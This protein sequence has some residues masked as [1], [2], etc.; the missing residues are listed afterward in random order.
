MIP[1]RNLMAAC[2]LTDALQS[3]WVADITVM[4]EEGPRVI[5]RLEKIRKAIIASPEPLLWFS[6]KR[7]EQEMLFLEFLNRNMKCENENRETDTDFILNAIKRRSDEILREVI[8]RMI[9]EGSSN[10][11][12]LFHRILQ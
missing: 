6:K 11:K 3:K 10:T 9:L 5:L 12:N 1:E 2:G 7:M 4:M 8:L